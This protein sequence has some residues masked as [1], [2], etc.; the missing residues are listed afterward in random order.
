M[1]RDIL[2]M[3]KIYNVTAP[4]LQRKLKA[5][6]K[7]T[8]SFFFNVQGKLMKNF[9]EWVGEGSSQLFHPLLSCL[10]PIQC[11]SLEGKPVV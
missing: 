10:K 1:L 11:L 2:R 7:R 3:Y 5:K 4:F 8:T 9:Q 6:K